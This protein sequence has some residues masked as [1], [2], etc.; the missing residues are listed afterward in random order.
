MLAVLG[1]LPREV[2]ILCCDV[3]MMR[4][5]EVSGSFIAW[6]LGSLEVGDFGFVYLIY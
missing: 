5:I 1:S 6:S 2:M 3:V 4:D